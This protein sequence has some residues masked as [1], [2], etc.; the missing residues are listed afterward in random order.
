MVKLS[1]IAVRNLKRIT[2]NFSPGEIVLLTGVSGSGKSS[3]AFDTIYAAGRRRYLA[4]LPS[5]FAMHASAL[6]LPKVEEISGL[7]PTI[8]VKQNALSH[9]VHATVGSI[10]EIDQY[11]ALLFSVDGEAHDPL[12]GERL[13]L[14]SKETILAVLNELDEGTQLT[15]LSPCTTKDTGPYIRQGLTKVWVNGKTTP[16]YNWKE[17][18]EGA[19]LIIDTLIKKEDNSPRLQVG[20]KVALEIGNSQCAVWAEGILRTFCT[21]I[22]RASCTYK[23][24]SPHQFSIHSS[25]ERCEYCLGSGVQVTVENPQ[26]INVEHSIASHCC[27]FAGKYTTHLYRELYQA[28]ADV[29]GISLKT[30]WK[31]LPDIARHAFLYGKQGLT[32]PVC[33]FD[34]SLG[35]RTL[36]YR[37]W[38]G[39]LNE[40]G[41]KLRY[42]SHPKPP[43]GIRAIPCPHCHQTGLGSYPLAATWANRSF[44]DFQHLS[45][46]ELY[47]ELQEIH[48]KFS[49]SQE[50]LNG[51]LQRLEV[52]VDL[53]LSYLTPNRTLATL[54]GGER[55]RTALAK[56]LGANLMGITYVLDE[57]SIGLHPQDTYKLIGVIRKLRDQGN[58]V[59]LVEHEDQMFSVADRIIDIGPGAGKYG[60][61]VLFNGTPADFLTLSNSLTAQYLRHEREIPIPMK[62]KKTLGSLNLLHA[63]TH[64]LKKISVIFPLGQ[65]IAVTGVSGS[66]KSSLINDTLAPAVEAMLGGRSAP[67]VLKGEL[68]R[69]VHITRDLPGRSQRSIPLTYLK[70]F[71]A[72]RQL[73]ATQPTSQQLGLTIG[74]FSFNQSLGACPVCQGLGQIKVEEEIIP[75]TECKGKRFQEQVLQVSYRGKTIADILEMTAEEASYFFASIPSIHHKIE[76]LCTLGLHYLPLGR[77][78]FSLSGGEIQRLKLAQEVLIPTRGPTLYLLDE[79]TT[80]LH[81]HDVLVLIQVLQSLVDKGHTLIV[82]EHNMHIVKIADH[83]IELGP[84]GGDRGG[85]LLASCSP[86]QLATQDTATG[87]ALRSY[88]HNRP[89]VTTDSAHPARSSQGI[90][91]RD[92]HQHNLNHI[93]LTLPRHAITAISGPCASG[94]NTLIFDVLYAAGNLAYAELFPTYLRQ[95]LVK[96]TPQPLVR[97]VKGLSPVVAVKRTNR[98]DSRHTVASALAISDG[99]EQLFAHLGVPHIHGKPLTHVTPQI[100]AD[101][102]LAR[103][104]GRFATISIPVLEGQD[105]YELLKREGFVK[106]MDK[107]K[108][109]DIADPLPKK[110]KQPSI[111]IQHLKITKKHTVS[112][113]S[114]IS[115]GF[116]RAST[117][118]IAIQEE[119]FS[120]NYMLGWRDETSYYPPITR[121]LLSTDHEEGRCA[122][123]CGMGEIQEVS[124]L[125][126][127]EQLNA[128]SPE[129]FFSLLLPHEDLSVV[130]GLLKTLKIPRKP[131]SKLTESQ[132]SRLCLGTKA[133]PGLESL[134]TEYKSPL[135]TPLITSKTCAVCNGWGINTYA[136]SVSIQG[137]SLIDIY[138]EDGHFL[139]KFLKN[140]EK[141]SLT[142]ELLNRLDFLNQVGLSHLYLG[143]KQVSNGERFRL[144][145]AKMLSTNLTDIVYLLEDPFSGMHVKDK[146]II[147]QVMKRLSYENTVIST[148]RGNGLAE[149][150]DC[151]VTLGPG[152]GPNGGNLSDPSPPVEVSWDPR[153]SS[154]EQTLDV[155]VSAHNLN[156]LSISIPLQRL[157]TICGVSGSGKSTLLLEGCYPKAQELVEK[158]F[159]HIILLDGYPQSSSQRS[160]LGTYFDITPT[161]RNFYASLSSAKALNITA[162]MFST[163]TKLGQCPDCLGLGYHLIDRT[164]YALEKRPCTTCGGF[165]IQPL[166]QEVLYEGKHFGEVLQLPIK[167]IAERFFF[168]KKIQPPLKAL[169]EGGLDYLPLGQSLAFLS[170]G[171]KLAV[172]IARFITLAPRKP[173]LFL[174]DELSS[175]L[176][177]ANKCR[178]YQQLNSLVNVGHSVISIEHDPKLIALSDVTIELGPGAGKYGGRVLF[179]GSPMRLAKNPDKS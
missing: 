84:E 38:K 143:Q 162:S 153:P 49:S 141:T 170:L 169:I 82:I 137:C 165:R 40:I 111:V 62:R 128:Y 116:S 58:T 145:L 91:I 83:V 51:L 37:L 146:P 147:T 119:G 39:V 172:K 46:G 9:H 142:Q 136:Q 157:V 126:R 66:G 25:E 93:D 60:G 28:F 68:A 167:A 52:L 114:A 164:F 160:D 130:T 23:P 150:A 89:I 125:S 31:N 64:N 87:R 149:I 65:L 14:Q 148:D 72:I 19:Y 88:M 63:S 121:K 21:Q 13:E 138:Q 78:L 155:R 124:L 99:L 134:L 2:V 100:I 101:E 29:M 117:I 85:F 1:G 123:C 50:I 73:F 7:S 127:R 5:F 43:D 41:E 113:L 10:T 27:L 75:C 139:R 57:P 112:M 173:T 102:L 15:L 108:I 71:D 79:P 6:P 98:R 175:G 80:G 104:E 159:E 94:K 18:P 77:P 133:Q 17:L 168:L 129:E 161:L 22:T 33:L 120:K 132:F 177:A 110:L 47:A 179:Q 3:L 90:T 171:E 67:L 11:L 151:V 95:T 106:F 26:L 166:T 56:Y 54:S 97:E 44:A 103:H 35:K 4:T 118:T 152:S 158:V 48:P 55:E 178:L 140:L 92:A 163:N 176:D 69:Y 30:P 154:S 76:S 59:I 107:G 70:A 144:S 81:T 74:H 135:L 174:L 8:A 16:I 34:P 36:S 53:G 42:S 105:L 115:L 12:T 96:K 32:L 24:L 131:M 20:I 122:H 45:L 61:E 109:Y 156:D 86:E